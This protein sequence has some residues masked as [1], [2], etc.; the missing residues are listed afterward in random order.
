MTTTVR[1]A[2]CTK[3]HGKRASS[4]DLDGVQVVLSRQT[5]FEIKAIAAIIII[6]QQ[7]NTSSCPQV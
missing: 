5:L 2:R 7:L 4:V 1:N 6:K 3:I